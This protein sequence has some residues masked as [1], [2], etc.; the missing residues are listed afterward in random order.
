M[1]RQPTMPVPDAPEPL[2]RNHL[3]RLRQYFRSSG[4]P[5]QDN[6][7][8]DLLR[9]GLVRREARAGTLES[10]VVTEAGI[11]RLA[12]QLECNRRAYAEHDALIARVSRWLLGQRRLVFRNIALR[13]RVDDAWALS[14]PDVFSVRHVTSSRR[15]HPA[16]HEVK[17]RRADL[18]GDLKK[19]TKRRGYQSYSQSFH[20]VIA[21]GIADASEIPEDCGVVVATSKSLC[22]VRPSPYRPA[23][24]TTAQWVALARAGAELGDDDDPQLAL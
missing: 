12:M 22:I 23:A 19:D 16:V 5:C 18:L 11:A 3:R 8:L 20:Y 13:A 6:I 1:P 17:V 14:K 15:L 4:W 10:I 9:E 24:L 7:E 21:E 2:T